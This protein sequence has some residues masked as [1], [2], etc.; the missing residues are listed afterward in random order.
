MSR[1][2]SPVVRAMI[3][4]YFMFFRTF[5]YGLNKKISET[6]P[7]IKKTPCSINQ[8][9]SNSLIYYVYGNLI[10]V[11]EV[12]TKTQQNITQIYSTAPYSDNGY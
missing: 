11:V 10:S 12:Q 8:N 9:Q 4:L 7:F 5:R 2:K 3:V 6:A 1:W